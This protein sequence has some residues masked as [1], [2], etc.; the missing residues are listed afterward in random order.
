MS[1]R[2]PTAEEV[3]ELFIAYGRLELYQ[4]PEDGGFDKWGKQRLQARQRFN[5]AFK[6][7]QESRGPVTREWFQQR[8]GG[9]EA[10]CKWGML[11]YWSPDD[12]VVLTVYGYDGA[13]RVK[14]DPLELDDITREQIEM[15]V[16]V[17]GGVE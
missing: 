7:W 9:E 4:S 10:C 12:I 15:L 1:E 3:L 16:R 13:G 14:G 8:F 17:L 5:E 11:A 6:R 2:P